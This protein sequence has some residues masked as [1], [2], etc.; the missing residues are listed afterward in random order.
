MLQGDLLDLMARLKAE[1]R[2]FCVVTVVR[3]E[4]ATS[5]K[6]GA[7]AVVT[8]EGEIHGFVGGGCVTSAAR[9]AALTALESGIAT[10]VRVKPK[11]TVV[12]PVDTDGVTLYKSSCPSGGTIELFVDPVRAP[13]QWVVC[14]A[15]PVAAAMI[16]L[17]K[18]MGYRTTAAALA[19][20]HGAIPGADGYIAGFELSGAGLRPQDAVVVATQGK[21][22]LDA[23]RAAL[24][25]KA[26][27]VAMVGS[28]KKA[29]ALRARLLETGMDRGA[30]DRLHMPAG[31]DIGA[32]GPEE[33]ALSIFGEFIARKRAAMPA[34]QVAA[35]KHSGKA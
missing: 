18:A 13:R 24:C 19:E 21:R 1:T 31:L 11:E 2:E 16:A 9:G 4:D 3:T 34:P 12:G 17:A 33:I 10:L 22:D 6:A 23:L 25:T 15:S 35:T 5:A 14:G 8:R 30:L 32:I 26:A 7:K 28:R 27:Y 29:A 20:D